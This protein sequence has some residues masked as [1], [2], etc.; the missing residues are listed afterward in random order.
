MEEILELIIKK[1]YINVND[2]LKNRTEMNA[3]NINGQ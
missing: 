3:M 2:I 1:M